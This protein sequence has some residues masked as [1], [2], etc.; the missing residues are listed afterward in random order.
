MSGFKIIVTCFAQGF[1]SP[2]FIDRPDAPRYNGGVRK[3][4]FEYC[5]LRIANRKTIRAKP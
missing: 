1:N 2:F 3:L 4:Q 5:E